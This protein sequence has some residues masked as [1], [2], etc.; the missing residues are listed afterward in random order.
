MGD[1]TPLRKPPANLYEAVEQV[2]ADFAAG[3]LEQK[4]E[5]G[6]TSE[7][8]GFEAW[9]RL[10]QSQRTNDV[11]F[12]LGAYADRVLDETRHREQAG[13]PFNLADLIV[14]TEYSYAGM[15][16]D[17]DTM[18]ADEIDCLT[19]DVLA[20]IPA[21]EILAALKQA[22]RHAVPAVLKAELLAEQT[23]AAAT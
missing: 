10:A 11:L 18:A 6:I 8:I 19:A 23:R 13:Q 2:W 17:P 7:L 15:L 4:P 14:R 9:M 1:V 21:T 5:Q 16:G 20:A 12:A 22:L 3:R